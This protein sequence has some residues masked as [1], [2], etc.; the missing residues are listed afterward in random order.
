MRHLIALAVLAVSTMVPVVAISS[1]AS[2]VPAQWANCTTVNSR[3][4]HGV[5]RATAHDHT[6]GKPV[7]TF[8]H[9]TALY[10]TAMR[11]NGR[12]DGDHDGIACEKA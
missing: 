9:D 6:S 8:R 11:A 7:T 2:A 10:N 12:L 4:P 3:L 1:S 5:G